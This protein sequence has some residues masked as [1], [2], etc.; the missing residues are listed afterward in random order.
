MDEPQSIGEVWTPMMQRICKGDFP[1]WYEDGDETGCADEA[2]S[3]RSAAVIGGDQPRE[4]FQPV[5]FAGGGGLREWEKE[6][7][8]V[9]R[10]PVSLPPQRETWTSGGVFVVIGNGCA[11]P[12]TTRVSPSPAA[13]LFAITIDGVRVDHASAFE[14]RDAL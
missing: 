11:V 6:D 8:E 4:E 9:R 1:L 2:H 3:R 10:A 5:A 7:R 14:R 12:A 13:R